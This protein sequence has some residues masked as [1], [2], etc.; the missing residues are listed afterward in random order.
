M[1]KKFDALKLP[2]SIQKKLY[3]TYG[4][5]Q[6]IEGQISVSEYPPRNQRD[7]WECVLLGE[8]DVTFK[9]NPPRQN[10]KQKALD[11]LEEQKREVL[12]ENHMRLKRV[13]EKIDQLL[14]I[15]YQPQPEEGTN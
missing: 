10:I 3:I 14:A 9:I 5:G 7:G 15:E 1:K 12:A 11:A 13:Q 8:Q 4:L 6:F 2:K